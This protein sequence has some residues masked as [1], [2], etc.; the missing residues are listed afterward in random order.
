MRVCHYH[1]VK[2]GDSRALQIARDFR[3]FVVLTAVDED[4]PVFRADK[5]TVAL[6]DVDEMHRYGPAHAFAVN[7]GTKPERV[8]KLVPRR[9]RVIYPE[10]LIERKKGEY[11]QYQPCRAKRRD[12]NRD[13]FS[14][15]FRFLYV[16]VR[17]EP[18]PFPKRLFRGHY[19]FLSHCRLPFC[20]P[21]MPE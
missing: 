2:A 8:V 21:E 5:R 15:L 13:R 16:R 19:F 6:S 1:A 11:K 14:G 12:L 10:K 4:I 3:V 7:A 18:F 20:C 17:K 9:E